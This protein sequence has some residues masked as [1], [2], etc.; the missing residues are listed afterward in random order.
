[1]SAAELELMFAFMDVKIDP[2]TMTAQQTTG[3][4]LLAC[5]LESDVAAATGL[6]VQEIQQLR[7]DLIFCFDLQALPKLATSVESCARS[8]AFVR[9]R[10]CL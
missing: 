5:D 2:V 4:V 8:T 1:M 7:L 3:D 10:V 6:F 9:A